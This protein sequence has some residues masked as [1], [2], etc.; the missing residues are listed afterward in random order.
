MEMD[1]KE[2]LFQELETLH[3][4]ISFDFQKVELLEFIG[5]DEV[6]DYYIT[7]APLPDFPDTLF[8]VFAL[9]EDYLYNFEMRQHISLRHVLPL[10]NI[11]AISEGFSGKENN[12]LTISFRVAGLGYCVIMED[13]VG[14]KEYLRRFSGKVKDTIAK[15][16]KL[17]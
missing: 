14:S 10:N 11:I 15:K 17:E 12:F 2:R 3:K 6:I 8:D 16:L 1:A 5:S 13:E 4:A 7:Q 9:T